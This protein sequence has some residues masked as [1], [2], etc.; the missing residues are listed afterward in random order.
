L[1]RTFVDSSVIVAIGLRELAADAMASRVSTASTVLAH[2]LLEA[3]VRS[4]CRREQR[5]VDAGWLA[6]IEWI[7]PPGRLAAEIDRVLDAG[8]LRGADCWHLA[9]AL[10]VA[11]QPGKETFL[12]LDARQ[13][14]VAKKLG[15]RV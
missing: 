11:P 15:F 4:A 13:R 7:E 5:T 14:A 12:T 9:V 1:T 2:P 10:Y 3:E 6:G 8:Y